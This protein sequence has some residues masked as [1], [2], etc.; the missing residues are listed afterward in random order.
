MTVPCKRF[1]PRFPICETSLGEQ[2]EIGS[3]VQILASSPLCTASF[4]STVLSGLSSLG[5]QRIPPGEHTGLFHPLNL[6][7]LR[8][9]LGPSAQTRRACSLVSHV[10]VRAIAIITIS[11][12]VFLPEYYILIVTKNSIKNLPHLQDV[13]THIPLFSRKATGASCRESDPVPCNEHLRSRISL[14]HTDGALAFVFEHMPGGLDEHR[15]VRG[16]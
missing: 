3:A 2:A 4:V 8:T 15:R 1:V 16:D 11:G 9:F 10:P 7:K 12:R 13:E 6:A 5:S 14:L